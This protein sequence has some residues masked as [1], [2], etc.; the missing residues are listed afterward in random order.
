[1]LRWWGFVVWRSVGMKK[2]SIICA[3]LLVGITILTTD[4]VFAQDTDGDGIPD[5]EDN[6]PNHRNG[7]LLGTCTS[8][9]YVVNK[10]TCLSNEECDPNG[11]CSMNQEDT[12]PPQGNGIGDA[13]DCEADFDC[14]SYVDA[15]DVSSFLNDFGRNQYNNPCINEDQCN[16][17]FSCDNNVDAADV[18]KF[19]ED[20]GR[21]QY[22]NPC[23]PC[24]VGDWCNYD[25]ARCREECESQLG[26][27]LLGCEE[28]PPDSRSIC[29]DNCVFDY[30]YNCIP[31]CDVEG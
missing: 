10:K 18:I 1:M 28:L 12:Y 17:D 19:L 4:T 22:S 2:L 7:P 9:P 24:V 21:S 30:Q 20:F 23:P 25:I 31:A 11:F 3:I 27:C 8:G 14:S 5:T 16:G 26:I 13:C 6:C 15:I 29:N